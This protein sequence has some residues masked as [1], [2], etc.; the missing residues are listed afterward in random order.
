MCRGLPAGKG[1]VMRTDV[2]FSALWP[3][4]RGALVC[5]ELGRTCPGPCVL[6]VPALAYD[7]R[8]FSEEKLSRSFATISFPST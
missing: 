3:P 7:L 1:P 6:G 4:T 5:T 2:L 8:P